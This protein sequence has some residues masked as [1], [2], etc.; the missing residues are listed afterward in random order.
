MGDPSHSDSS[1]NDFDFDWEALTFSSTRAPSTDS[2]AFESEFLS[3]DSIAD[4]EERFS[5]DTTGYVADPA[6]TSFTDMDLGPARL[7]LAQSGFTSAENWTDL[8]SW[9][10]S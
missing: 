4:W 3:G 10:D 1:E 7:D 8:D 6:T 5:R 2:A 9:T